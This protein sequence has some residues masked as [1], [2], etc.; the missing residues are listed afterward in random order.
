MADVLSD[1]TVLWRKMPH[2]AVFICGMLA[3]LA[4]FQYLGN[5][6][7]GYV[8]TA[9]VFHWMYNAYNAPLSEDGHGNLIPFAVFALLIW[10][11]QELIQNDFKAWWP[12]LALMVLGLVLHVLGFMVQQTRISVLALFIGC[13]GLM[14]FCW[15]RGWLKVTLFPYILFL[16]CV[17]IGSLA[18]PVTFPLRLLVT[19]LSVSFCH[20]IL[21]IDVMRQGTII[22]GAEETFTYDVAAACSGMRSL[23]TL[24]PLTLAFAFMAYRTWWKRGLLVMLSV[25]LAVAGNTLRLISVI[26]IGDVWG[27]ETGLLWEQK[28]GFVTFL[29]AIAGVFIVDIW[30]RE[31]RL[32]PEEP[33]I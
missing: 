27:H 18:Q 2:K 31:P 28:L 7:F 8:D 23:L 24:V 29:V 13:Y 11:R 22:M 17:P 15:G 4:L 21:Q 33:A 9:S 12:A 19:E 16:F 25:P 1:L 30:L 14:G 26:C 32:K 6:T 20:L 10:K 5:S 3:W